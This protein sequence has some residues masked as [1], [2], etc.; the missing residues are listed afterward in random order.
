MDQLDLLRQVSE[1]LEQLQ[2]RYAVV[3]SFASG[4]WG[5]P[6]LTHDIDIVV[7]LDVFDARLLCRAFGPP[8]FYVSTTAAEEAVEAKSQF[9]LIHPA[10]GNKIDF[11]IAGESDWI[12]N[13]LTRAIRA[14]LLPDRKISVAQAEDVIL[15]KL[16]YYRDGGSEKHIR[17]ITGILETGVVDIDHAYLSKHA[18]ALGVVEEWQSILRK[19]GIQ[20]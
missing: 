18:Q 19:L 3:G 8:D 17:D 6:R 9:N 1:T 5:E 16:I 10:S 14:N 2:V 20:P 7:D 15:G 4:A 11:M 12:H 13:Q